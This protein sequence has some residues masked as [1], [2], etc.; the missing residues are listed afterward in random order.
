M[1]P[2]DL[3][4]EHFKG[5][6]PNAKELT[7]RYVGTLRQLPL[8]FLP[9]LLKEILDCDFKFPIELRTLQRELS[10][11]ASLS[12]QDLENWFQQFRAIHISRELES[13]NWVSAPAEFVERLSAYLWS[14]HQLDSFR[15]AALAYGDRLNKAVPPENP[16]IPRLGI[17]IIGRGVTGDGGALFRKLRAEGAYFS[18]VNPQNGVSLLLEA[19]AGRA[20]AHPVAYGHWYIDG[21]QAAS[22]SSSLTAVSYDSLLPA[23]TAL[24]RKMEA[25]TN[26]PGMG[27]EALRSSLARMSDAEISPNK[28]EDRILDHFSLKLLTEGSGTQ[29]F[30]TTFVQWAARE[31][32]RRAQPL[33]LVA[34]FAPRQK[35]K[36][37]NELLS[38]A[39]H[40]PEQDT[41]GSLV[42]ADMGAYYNWLNQQRL[43]GAPQSSFLAWFE[44]HNCAVVIGP[45]IPRGTES[46]K[47]TN[48]KELLTWI[49]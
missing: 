35:Q 27:P 31:A 22:H 34:R 44:D 4:P 38:P 1:V 13:S 15:T 10:Q 32:L 16:P 8:S 11:L 14:T 47:A 36:T 40:Q 39:S 45:S 29:I 6:S 9:S 23:R 18:A 26:R 42:D 43:S 37:M 25:E 17:S 46:R 49:T 5:Y 21:G 7:V 48:V 33:T 2:L 24:L 28:L 12:R 19:A 3:K 41:M 30:S 20:E